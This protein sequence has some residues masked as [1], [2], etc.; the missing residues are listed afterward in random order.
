MRWR[1]YLGTQVAYIGSPLVVPL[2]AIVNVA[3]ALVVWIYGVS[4]ALYYKNVWN[5]AYLPF[6]STSSKSHPIE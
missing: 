3:V 4:T 2:W 6:Q 1:V 5:T